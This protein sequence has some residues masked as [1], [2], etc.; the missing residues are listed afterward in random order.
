MRRKKNSA[1]AQIES[2]INAGSH[3]KEW[4]VPS[5]LLLPT[6]FMFVTF[7]FYPFIRAIINAFSATGI[8]GEFIKFVGFENFKLMVQNPGFWVTLRNTFLLAGLKLILTFPPAMVIAMLASRKGK[9]DRIYQT[10]YALPMAFSAAPIAA[11]WMYI[12]RQDSG[13][14]NQLLGTDIAWLREE[15][16]A[17]LVVAIVSAWGGIAGSAFG[18]LVGFRNVSEEV[19]E[20]AEIDGANWWVK[21][22]KVMIPLAS[23]HIFYNLFFQVTG[24]FKIFGTIDLLTKGGPAGS[25]TTLLYRIYNHV[26]GTGYIQMACAEAMLLFVII[27][28]FARIEQKVED[29]LVFYQ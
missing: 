3:K 12:F 17:L 8:Q 29:K 27:F 7:T 13:L 24:A 16:W 5:L 22:F 21:M 26:N 18:I 1:L 11:I 15:K 25:T 10:I 20:A 23:P 28:V 9:G 2:Q 4:L 19:L 6:M 14:L